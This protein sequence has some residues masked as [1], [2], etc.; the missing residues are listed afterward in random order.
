MEDKFLVLK[1]EDLDKL[2]PELKAMINHIC[3]QYDR[4]RAREG[5]SVNR[6]YVV[7]QDEPYAEEVANL[8]AA[9]EAAKKDVGFS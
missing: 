7:N 5:K 2:S 1:R 8:I 6:Y 4:I 9:G 3:L